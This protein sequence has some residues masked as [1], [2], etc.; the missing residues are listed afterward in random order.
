[1][2]VILRAVL[3]VSD[4]EER[5]EVAKAVQDVAAM[6]N[7]AAL[8]PAF[9]WDGGPLTPGGRFQRR[10]RRLDEIVFARI[11]EARERPEGDRHDIL[12][13]LVGAAYEDG[14]P[15]PDR[16]IRDEVVGLVIAGQET[17][18]TALAWA[19]DLILRHPP[20]HARVIAEAALGRSTYTDATIKEALRVRPPV[21]AAARVAQ[22]DTDLGGFRVPAGTRV[23]TPMTLIQRDEASFPDPER[24]EPERFLRGKPAPMTWIPFGGGNRRC[25]GAGFAMLE[26]RVVL[27]TILGRAVLAPGAQPERPRL[28][29]VIME[30]A[31]GMRVRYDGSRPEADR[32]WAQKTL[33]TVEGGPARP[34]RV[35]RV[36]EPSEPDRGRAETRRQP[37]D[38]TESR[39]TP[40]AP[41]SPPPR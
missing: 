30:P 37:P 41:A 13:L 14:T 39:R 19:F 24:F 26:M 33:R 1:M 23:W 22:R 36:R 11:A 34:M 21:I 6:G 2:E 28:N 9:R 5:A 20:V 4:R 31:R 18:G 27:Q 29:N 32:H 40:R 25:V 12:S 35:R 15:L 17:T 10:L 7:A 3:G 8:G 38:R 16:E